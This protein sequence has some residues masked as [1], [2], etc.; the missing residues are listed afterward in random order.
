MYAIRSYYGLI[1]P[2]YTGYIGSGVGFPV[3]QERVGAV[4]TGIESYN[5]V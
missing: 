1:T 3:G 2:R 4:Q 5:F